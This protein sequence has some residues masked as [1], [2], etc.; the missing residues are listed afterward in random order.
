MGPDELLV[1]SNENEDMATNGKILLLTGFNRAGGANRLHVIDVRDP[2][3]MKILATLP[4][5]G[6][7]TMT[8]LYDCKWAY[9][10][11]SGPSSVGT[12]VDLRN[13]RKPKL[14]KKHWTDA[15]GDVSAHDVTEVR[16]GL[17]VTSSSP[18]FVLDVKNPAKPRVL[19]RT[20]P[21]AP[22][23]TH[24]NIWPRRGKD[25]FLV[26]ASEGVNNGRCEL[27]GEDGKTLQI[28]RTDR[29]RRRGLRPAGSYTL[30]NGTG[31]DGHPPLDLFGIQGCS[32]HWA[33]EH[34]SF[35]NGGLLAM[36]A[37]SHGVRLLDISRKG[38]PREVGYFLKDIQAAIDIEWITNRILYVVEDGSGGGVD[39]IKYTGALPDRSGSPTGG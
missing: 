35:R 26:S 39:V 18:M 4:E 12:I 33:Q 29:W 37:Y 5:A 24:N 13:P 3:K 7:H 20:Q 22:N 6:G 36:A 17:V 11:S 23:T 16:P 28:W 21:D 34:P 27:Y 14:L 8:C 32:A 19:M 15:T 9:G 2:K 25:R 31:S 30:E 10:S 1:Q 38:K